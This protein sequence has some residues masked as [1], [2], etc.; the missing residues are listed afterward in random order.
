MARQE[1]SRISLWLHDLGVCSTIAAHLGYAI[2]ISS[3][4]DCTVSVLGGLTNSWMVE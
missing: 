1:F 4:A 3:V 2:I